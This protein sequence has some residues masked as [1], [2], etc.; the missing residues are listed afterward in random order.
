MKKRVL[1]VLLCLIFL[2]SPMLLAG[3]GEKEEIKVSLNTTNYD[4]FLSVNITYSDLVIIDTG[5][6]YVRFY[7]KT[8]IGTLTTKKKMTL[9][10]FLDCE[11]TFT[12]SSTGLWALK[13]TKI[14]IN[15]PSDGEASVS[16][17]LTQEETIF[18]TNF[19]SI[20]ELR[21]DS[22]TGFVVYSQ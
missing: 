21:V 7:D 10:C 22:I 11:I 20:S 18:T 19:P 9:N 14:K 5:N 4:K 3:C 8:C 1:S 16:F 2:A 17:V 13:P 6:D 15:M 12:F